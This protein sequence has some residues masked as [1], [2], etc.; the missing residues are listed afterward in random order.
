MQDWGGEGMWYENGILGGKLIN[1]RN[2]KTLIGIDPN[3]DVSEIENGSYLFYGCT[4]LTEWNV[5]LPYTKNGQYMFS[6][7][8]NLSTFESELTSLT[9]GNNM[10]YGCS[11]LDSF[12]INALNLVSG[13]NMFQNTRLNNFKC[14]MDMPALKNVYCMFTDSRI[15]SYK[16]SLRELND[17]FVMFYRCG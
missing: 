12:N 7:C 13:S 15:K 9:T 16:G 1:L 6:G 11:N 17:G 8:S 4:G 2:D 5:D 10:F 3:I 14:V